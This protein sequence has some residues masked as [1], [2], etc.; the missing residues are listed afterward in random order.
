MKKLFLVTKLSLAGVLAVIESWFGGFDE[1]LSL[2]IVLIGIDF[3][4]GLLNAILKKKVSSAEI[5]KG[6]VRKCVELILIL[7][8]YR[9]DVVFGFLEGEKP[10][11]TLRMFSCVY[12]G[13]EEGVSILENAAKLGVPLPKTVIKV[14]KQVPNELGS[15]F[16]KAL[17]SFLSKWLHIDIKSDDDKKDE[18]K[19]KEIKTED[20]KTED[21]KKM[22]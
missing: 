11:F 18:D 10:L 5:R 14:L 13:I 1:G 9:M 8:C 16:S 20:I 6:A 22:S 2:L 4:L 12:F 7:L 19:E 3:I 17:V 15:S 21:D